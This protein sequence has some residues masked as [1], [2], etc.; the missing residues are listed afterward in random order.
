MAKTA[1]RKS[2]G[3]GCL[4]LRGKTWF[5]RWVIDGK[6]FTR[7]T[8]TS[9]KRD[10]E[11]KL[12]EFT[13]PFRLESKVETL[14][15][16]A[17]KIDG[18][19]AEIE[20]W[21]DSQAAMTMLQA[22]DAFKTTPKGKTPR[23]R[24]I[25]P[26]A[27]TL[28]DYEGR[29]NAFCK[30]MEKHFPKKNEKGEKI[31]WE[32]RQIGKEHAQR[33]IAEIGAN[34]SANTR[35]KTLTFLRLVFKVLAEKARI[36]ANPFD[37]MDAA[38]LAVN[39]K[40]PLTLTELAEIA[41][42]LTGNGEMELLFSLGFYTGARLGDCVQMRWDSIDLEG[43]KIRYTPHK[44]A[45]GNREITLAIA[46]ALFSL[47]EKVPKMGRRGLV[48]PELGAL[49]LK[50]P[51]AVS[52]RVQQVFVDAGIETELEVKGYG[53]K[54]ARVGFHSLRHAHITALLEGG[55]P[56]DMVRQQAGHSTL[57][58]TAHYYH[59]SEKA[60]K[61]ATDAL[62]EIGNTSKSKL[63]QILPMLDELEQADL[64][65]LTKRINEITD[66]RKVDPKE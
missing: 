14:E 60:L 30:W 3:N 45:K 23:G 12:T 55:V 51:S 9:V 64:E 53:K 49:Y 20:E 62:P 31:P 42:N 5:A 48:L 29:W 40:R 15:A 18:V 44:T 39:R 50:D 22:W 17:V 43:R 61:A 28:A 38:P 11:I 52:K 34:R 21:K 65:A 16:V 66:K 13:A 41:K 32:L 25:E 57:G 1:R 63:D 56:M 33:Y 47:L 24:V 35:N 6:T 54:I 7:T 37:G 8:G 10:A 19:K 2:K 26:G 4:V 59:A 46:P 27:R 36:K 58:M